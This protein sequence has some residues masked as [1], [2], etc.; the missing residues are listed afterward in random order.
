MEQIPIVCDF[1][2]SPRG[3]GVTLV[4]WSPGGEAGHESE[5][6]MTPTLIAGTRR[7]P[8]NW[9]VRQRDLI[10]LMDRA[11]LP[12]VKHATRP[13]GTLIQ[14]TVWTSMDGTDNGYEA[15]LSFPLFYILGGAEHIHDLARRQWDAITWQYASYNTV[16]REFVTGFDWFHHSESY[17]Y[18][19]YLG[20]ANP[21]HFIDRHRAL[22]Y[23]AMYIGEDPLAPNWDAD[24]R[25][26]RGPLNGSHGPRFV[27][28]QVD[29]D[30]HRPILAHYLAPFE[31]I[32]GA[33]SRDPM[34]KVDWTDDEM[35]AKVLALINERMTRCDVPL[36]LS[37]TSLVTN[38]YLYS[39]DETYKRWVLDYLQAWVER[40]DANGGIV[41]DNIGPNGQIGELMNGK[42]WGGYYGWRW[43]HG[44]RNIV[45][46]AFVAGSCAALM[47]G[48]MSY[49]DL[50]RSQLDVLW[51]QR[52]Q[53]DGSTMLPA[54]HGDQG[55]FDY[56]PPDPHL[57]IHLYYLSQSDE[58]LAR[59]NE[60][61]PDRKDFAGLPD[62]WGNGKA[63][64]C[65][66]QAWSTYVEGK[67]PAFPEQVIETTYNGVCQSLN[68]LEADDSD[69]Q[70]RECYHF[71]PLCPVLPEGLVQM[72]MGT[73]AA[74]YN[75]GLLQ[76]HVRY[77]DPQAR[78]AGLPPHVAALLDRVSADG[79]SLTLV[80]T[81]PVCGHPVLIQSGCF[82]EHQFTQVSAD[83]G[84]GTAQRTIVNGKHL[85][86]ELGPAAQVRLDLGI[87]RFAHQPS[88]AFPPWG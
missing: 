12:F 30:Y 20:L 77:F 27:T 80:N 34:F 24:R 40:R 57:Y 41:P 59:L 44:A 84:S 82:G 73:P 52:K 75:G 64:I 6:P 72:T 22:R 56:R 88:Y 19:Y 32:A 21:E 16:D 76:A 15:F 51:S 13:D 45:E 67:N 87:K 11:A 26:I 66:P 71:Q 48:D 55:W 8:P 2:L 37:A 39:G 63:G 43:P 38:A 83:D 47:T 29:W 36:N 69:P 28:T 85:R 46:P 35:F 74:V 53:V 23:A 50:C 9:A 81:D 65:P 68:R 62:D 5:H 78:R 79:A 42:W 10:A 18:I 1:D 54:R 86:V 60:V 70:T 31:D 33:D 61:F 3:E 58:D 49:L 7:N 17:T 4:A 14:R 25:M